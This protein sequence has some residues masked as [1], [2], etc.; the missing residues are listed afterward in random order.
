MKTIHSIILDYGG[1]I[2]LPQNKTHINNMVKI[3]NQNPSSF[4]DVY[5]KHRYSYDIGKLTGT[6]YWIKTSQQFGYQPK[7][8]EIKELIIEDIKSWTKINHR[9]LHFIIDVRKIIH[10][11]SIISNMPYD[12]LY[13]MKKHFNWLEFFDELTF[14]CEIG[15]N[16]PDPG[17]YEICI[18]RIGIHPCEC[19]FVDDSPDNVEGAKKI[20][21]NAIHFK[22]YDQ[23]VE[24]LDAEYRLRNV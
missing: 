22:S 7:C 16:K 2:S 20:G 17:I 11:L 8:S 1:V 15:V 18:D 6:E 24:K 19:L 10:N 21:M 4:M 23:F 13:Y 9:M 5:R 14:S 12:I 3:L